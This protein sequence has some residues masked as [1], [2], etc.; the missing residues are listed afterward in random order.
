MCC[1]LFH[2]PAFDKPAGK[3][4]RHWAAGSGCAIH[5]DRPDQ[6][7][8]FFCLWMTDPTVADVWKPDRSRIVLSIFPGNGFVYA[9]V[10]PSSPH[11]WRKQPYFDDLR[12][13]AGALA[14]ANRRVIVF[15]DDDATLITARGA[16]PLGQ[17][18]PDESFVL[19]PVF[20]PDGPTVRLAGLV[21]RGE[22]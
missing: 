7:R 8:E 22:A 2:I 5:P 18:R 10:D 13:M 21:K 16:T 14:E 19:E 17:M 9:Q 12:R 11:A 3:W 20:G 15:V 6:C 4:C 1:K